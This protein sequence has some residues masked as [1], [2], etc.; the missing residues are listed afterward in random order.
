MLHV[1]VTD[2]GCKKSTELH[3]R[4]GDTGLKVFTHPLVTGFPKTTPYS[5]PDSGISLNQNVA[6]GGTPDQVHNGGDSVLWTASAISG[7]WDFAS[8]TQAQ[9][10]SNS[11]DATST[12]NNS[13]AQFAKGS[14]LTTASYVS[15]S[16]YIYVDSWSGSGTKEVRVFGWDTG[17]GAAVGDEVNIGSFIDTDTTGS[18]QK[19]TIP[20]TLFNFT[21][22]TI[23]AIRVRTVDQGAG[24]PPNYY[25]DTLQFEETGAPQIFAVTADSDTRYHVA[26]IIF[27]WA[28]VGTG[29]TAYAYDKIGALSSLTNGITVKTEQE[30]REIFTTTFR[31]L[32]DILRA[33]GVVTNKVDDGTNTYVNIEV[34]FT[35][36]GGI[37]LS[38]KE[39]DEFTIQ[40]SDDLSGL[41]TF[42]AFVRG[43]VEET[44]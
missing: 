6:S 21:Q 26:T 20:L 2:P 42:N 43:W 35:S 37:F 13:V 23:D 27:S 18:W 40:I 24:P 10:G 15:L 9:A 4:N 3:T 17:T 8:S 12:S 19:F 44:G 14:N 16:G 22:A 7:I 39:E 5:N 11:V 25:L 28:D 33:G 38:A 36:V 1:R 32:G 34:D 31:T 41:L 30:G 29:G